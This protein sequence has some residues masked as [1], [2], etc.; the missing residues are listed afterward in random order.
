MASQYHPVSIF[1]I[2]NPCFISWL[3]HANAFRARLIW[4]C[5]KYANGTPRT[6]CERSGKQIC[7]YSRV[8]KICRRPSSSAPTDVHVRNSLKRDRRCDKTV[9]H[10]R[11]PGPDGQRYPAGLRL[12]CALHSTHVAHLSEDMWP[13]Y[14]ATCPPTARR[15]SLD[16]GEGLHVLWEQTR[17][18][19]DGLDR[20]ASHLSPKQARQRRWSMS[21][22]GAQHS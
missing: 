7:L 19:G 22:R 17:G 3:Q 20:S 8:G 13:S 21:W 4:I 10:V 2:P 6:V 11:V 18:G 14:Q 9:S 1:I 16:K 5:D 15:S 12:R